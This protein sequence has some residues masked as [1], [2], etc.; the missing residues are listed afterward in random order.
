MKRY[1]IFITDLA[2]R[3][4]L[5]IARYISAELRAPDTALRFIDEIDEA[6]SKL[7]LMPYK[8]ALVLDEHLR[9]HGYRKVSIKNYIVFY[10]IDEDRRVVNVE[11]VLYGRRDWIRI[12]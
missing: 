11:R 2:E 7:E 5:E 9:G 12:L 4:I 1:D 3:D 8:Y 10:R 6:V